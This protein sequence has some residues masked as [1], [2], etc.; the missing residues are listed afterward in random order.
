MAVSGTWRLFFSLSCSG[1]YGSASITFARNGTV[2]T[3]DGSSG[4]WLQVDGMLV[5]TFGETVYAGNVVG[6]AIVG[7]IKGWNGEPGCFYCVQ[8]PVTNAAAEATGAAPGKNSAG[9]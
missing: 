5:W 1:G 3:D 2:T 4:T 8:G 9:R 6:S 7:M